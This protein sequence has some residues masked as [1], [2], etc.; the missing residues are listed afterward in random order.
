MDDPSSGERTHVHTHASCTVHALPSEIL[1]QIA[2]QLDLS[3]LLALS[4]VSPT[5]RTV[6]RELDPFTPVVSTLLHD[7]GEAS[8]ADQKILLS[9]PRR[10]QL[11]RANTYVEILARATRYFLLSLFEPPFMNDSAWKSAFERRFPREVVSAVV[12]ADREKPWVAPYWRS[13]FW[14]QLNRLQHIGETA[15]SRQNA[16]TSYMILFRP[17]RL[18]MNRAGTAGF[19]PVAVFETLKTQ[20]AMR[21]QS[22]V[23]RTIRHTADTQLVIKYCVAAKPMDHFTANRVATELVNSTR[24]PDEAKPVPEGYVVV[25]PCLMAAYVADVNL[26]GQTMG[27]FG[28]T[29]VYPSMLPKVLRDAFPDGPER[30]MGY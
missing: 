4:Q 19:D 10:S 23:T 18:T 2:V 3:S 7:Y 11:V 25:G 30:L 24:A 5:W 12:N 1:Y 29:D 9:L 16:T 13:R 26:Q 28:L 20:N 22:T 14:G 8:S 21:Q 15:C 6:C 17:H 27:L